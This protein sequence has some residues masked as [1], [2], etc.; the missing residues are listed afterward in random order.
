[1]VL[2]IG[3]FATV[4]PTGAATTEHWATKY[5]ATMVKEGVLPES[6]NW[7]AP[8]TADDF[9]KGLSKV[10]G[11]EVGAP[12]AEGFNRAEMVKLAV[13][14]STYTGDLK[15]IEEKYPIAFCHSNDEEKIPKDMVPYFNMAYRPQWQLLTYRKDRK[16]AFDKEPWY[17]EAAYMLYMLKYPP[18]KD[19]G[20]Q[21]IVVTAQEPDTLNPFTTTA[22]SATLLGTFYGS[23]DVTYDDFA[24]RYPDQVLRVPS[25]DNGD[26]KVFKNPV[27]G[28]DNMSVVYR[29]RPGMYYP[30]MKGET[31]DKKHEITADDYL[32]ALRVGLSPVI[33]S[34]SRSGILK[35]DYLRKIDKYTCEI[36]FNEVYT[37][38]TWGLGDFYKAMFELDFYTDPGNF[39][40]RDDFRDYPSGPYRI[41]EWVRGD[42]IEFEPN[43]YALYAQPLVPKVIV[44]FMQDTNTIR[45]N[46]QAGN[47]DITTNA[48]G[49]LETADIEKKLPL[50]KFYYT[51]GT[52]YEH[53]TLNQFKDKETGKFDLFGDLRVRQAL[54]YALDRER[55][56][57]I[58][59]NGIWSIA[60]HHLSPKSKYYDDKVPFKY[61]Y[62][63]AKAEKLLDEAGWKLTNVGGELIRC[64]VD[65][66]GKPDPNKPFKTTLAT[67]GEQEFRRKN[68]EE[69]VKMWGQIGIKVAP[70]LRPAKELFGGQVLS[71]HQFEM[72]EF[73]WVSQPVRPNALMWRSDQVP[74]KENN[75][76]GQGIS[77]W[78]GSKEHDD[79]CSEIEKELPDVKLQELLN[80]ELRYWSENLPILPLF[81]R[82][83][84]DTATRDIQNIKPTG[85][86]RTINW[87]SAFWYR[88]K[89]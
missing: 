88:E 85:S 14:N 37:F 66:N 31:E 65:K 8:I 45:L 57:K 82:Y 56:T 20:Q 52:S 80:K 1:M 7:D 79:W 10:L 50:V 46:L 28:K 15:G 2:A 76:I 87:N 40:S 27:T 22:F 23:T 39:N 72:V 74:T 54:L 44:R 48:F 55:L 30:P 70:Q 89:K 17:S 19:P 47:I 75:W 86:Q 49:P 62:N 69:V 38:G 32:F 25:L 12:K 64:K 60:H 33:Q 5:V 36:S 73:A 18:N 16:T 13:D 9:A 24:T 41:K 3:V 11:K 35:Y 67:T 42:H 26:V 59:S 83:D 58:T 4:S 84:V 53:I 6:T 29:I 63:P 34:I 71:Q 43:P 77:G 51:P 81:Y 68:V 21:I 78:V 61:E